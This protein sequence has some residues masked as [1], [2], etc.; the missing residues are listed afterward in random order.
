MTLDHRIILA[1]RC[2]AHLFLQ[3]STCLTSSYSLVVGVLWILSVNKHLFPALI[4]QLSQT[5]GTNHLGV[6]HLLSF[7]IYQ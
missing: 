7:R 4:S 2:K 6:K 3:Y 1:C 5:S